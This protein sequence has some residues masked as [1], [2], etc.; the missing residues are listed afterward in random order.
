[1]MPASHMEPA[2]EVAKRVH[3]HL[4]SIIDPDSSIVAADD[5][6]EQRESHMGRM[7]YHF[8]V[9]VKHSNK[10]RIVHVNIV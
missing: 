2:E 4:R 10:V 7:A 5:I 8:A 6:V 9:V 1:M 3:N